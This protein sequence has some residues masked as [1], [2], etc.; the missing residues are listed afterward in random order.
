[1]STLETSELREQ[2]VDALC[3]GGEEQYAVHVTHGE[4]ADAVLPV[5]E[6]HV[7]KL[8]ELALSAIRA[9]ARAVRDVEAERDALAA[10]LAI[11]DFNGERLLV[12][13]E[14]AALST[15]LR[16]MARRV[17]RQR[18]GHA[19]TLNSLAQSVKAINRERQRR[20]AVSGL[21]RGMARRAVT[22]RRTTIG[23]LDDALGRIAVLVDPYTGAGLERSG[24]WDRGRRDAE[25]AVADVLGDVVDGKPVGGAQR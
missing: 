7:R 20:L 16:G 5:V 13:A 3:G 23:A 15:L 18:R 2:L 17:G 21:L 12:E 24:A 9:E 19:V 25:A 8:D 6:E 1:M 14:R 22:R 11:R 4:V 10:R